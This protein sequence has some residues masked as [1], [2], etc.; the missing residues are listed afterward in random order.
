MKVIYYTYEGEKSAIILCCAK[1]I[2]GLDNFPSTFSLFSW[3]QTSCCHCSCSCWERNA[4]WDLHF[5]CIIVYAWLEKMIYNIIATTETSTPCLWLPTPSLIC[6]I[7]K[8]L[9]LCI[10]GDCY[11]YPLNYHTVNKTS[12]TSAMYVYIIVKDYLVL[13]FFLL[14]MLLARVIQVLCLTIAAVASPSFCEE[15]IIHTHLL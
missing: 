15:G 8:L 10:F 1:I 14:S 4:S 6:I 7:N 12:K 2:I 3:S 9:K 5:L 11:E 13:K